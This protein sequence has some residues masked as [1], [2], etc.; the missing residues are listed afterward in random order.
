MSSCL[1]IF[2]NVS[3]NFSSFSKNNLKHIIIKYK[4]PLHLIFS[5]SFS[6]N[7]KTHSGSLSMALQNSDI[8]FFSFSC[9]SSGFKI[10][11]SFFTYPKLNFNIKFDIIGFS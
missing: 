1:N 10:F 7:F 5:S 2:F 6:T 4:F 8:S 11:L 9:I 3:C